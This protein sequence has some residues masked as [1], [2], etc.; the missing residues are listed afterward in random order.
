LYNTKK[1]RFQEE[2]KMA[3]GSI[4]ASDFVDQ[5]V[6]YRGHSHF[7]RKDCEGFYLDKARCV[8]MGDYM[9]TG[10]LRRLNPGETIKVHSRKI[11]RLTIP[12]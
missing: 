4:G 7:L 3:N 8:R 11:E 12:R 6:V 9:P 2:I 1:I 10:E 5:V